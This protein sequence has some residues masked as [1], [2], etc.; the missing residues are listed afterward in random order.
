VQTV[1]VRGDYVL[2]DILYM[3]VKSLA[4]AVQVVGRLLQRLCLALR[5]L[6]F[7]TTSLRLLGNESLALGRE[8]GTHEATTGSLVRIGRS[9]ARG[10]SHPGR[11]DVHI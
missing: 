8:R 9:G 6:D 1:S 3:L 5:L 11:D 10:R 4:E 7:E 2:S